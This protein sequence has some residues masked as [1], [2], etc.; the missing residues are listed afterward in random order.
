MSISS[1]SISSAPISG[2]SEAA[3]PNDVLVNDA[4]N[5]VEVWVSLRT[6][7]I[8]ETPPACTDIVDVGAGSVPGYPGIIL[9]GISTADTPIAHPA[10]IARD[11]INLTETLASQVAYIL[12]DSFFASEILAKNVHF[13]VTTS[14]SVA[15]FEALLRG[16]YGAASDVLR[17][18]DLD[19]AYAHWYVASSE[20]FNF[21]E[22][23]AASAAYTRTLSDGAL[24]GDVARRA[25]E[26]TLNDVLS[27]SDVVEIL[28]GVV[29]SDVARFSEAAETLMQYT[30][31]LADIVELGDSA[32]ALQS[33]SIA[34][35]EGFNF[36]GGLRFGDDDYVAY[37]TNTHTLGMTTYSNFNFNSFAPPYAAKTDG[38]YELTGDDDDGTNIT[39]YITTGL[40][41]YGQALLKRIPEV[42][43]GGTL[44]GKV[45][46][47]VITSQDGTRTSD[48]YS[49]TEDY[50]TEDTARFQVGR[51]LRSRYWQ[52]RL[53]NVQGSD[54][55]L[56]SLELRPLVL[57][58]RLRK[59]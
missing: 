49:L 55:D 38:I 11:T 56:D 18:G 25:F 57:S 29:L 43:I 27:T 41:D 3:D 37:V 2:S 23:Y 40:D 24:W 7:A 5:L 28:A 35:N 22:A 31:V 54:F 6:G 8:T 26:D 13:S 53:E 32:A 15:L 16:V 59:R 21:T 52:W 36:V 50:S 44:D 4:F 33:L 45:L 51:G 46:L 42:Y 12:L 20:V 39:A 10:P 47:K 9:E 30:A 34:I 19:E 48:W 58:R 17:A 1:S 14:D